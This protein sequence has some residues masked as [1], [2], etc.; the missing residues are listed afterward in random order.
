[1][2]N[3]KT[4][5]L[6]IPYTLFNI[7]SNHSIRSILGQDIK[8]IDYTVQDI[9]TD[10]ESVIVDVTFTNIDFDEFTIYF[11]S[12]NDLKHIIPN[13]DKYIVMI[14]GCGVKVTTSRLSEYKEYIPIRIHPMTSNNK[15]GDSQINQQFSYFSEILDKPLSNYISCMHYPNKSSSETMFQTPTPLYPSNYKPKSEQT[16]EQTISFYTKSLNQHPILHS[17]D[18]IKHTQSTPENLPASS[19]AYIIHIQNL[20]QT[21]PLY[22]IILFIDKR[23][24]DYFLYFPT[25]N[26]LITIPIINTILSFHKAELINYYNWCYI[27]NK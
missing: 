6:K 9:I 19:T 24:P 8:I 27:M 10:D 3:E 1:M 12:K 20:S 18:A 16:L 11:I 15:A 26:H 23:H 13:S 14:N 17:V 25:P 7:S 21:V 2:S 4:Q 5:R 22:G